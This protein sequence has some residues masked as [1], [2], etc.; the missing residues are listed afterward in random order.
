MGES[1]VDDKTRVVEGGA[2]GD[3]SSGGPVLVHGRRVY[4]CNDRG[5]VAGNSEDKA[6]RG[7]MR[8][9]DKT[10]GLEGRVEE[11]IEEC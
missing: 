7:N 11:K 9:R 8:G 3:E 6:G 2:I 5:E 1:T 10:S 4:T